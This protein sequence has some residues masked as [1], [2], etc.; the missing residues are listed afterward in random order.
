MPLFDPKKPLRDHIIILN[1]ALII[2]YGKGRKRGISRPA[3][4][5]DSQG[6][7]QPIGQCLRSAQLPTTTKPDD[8]PLPTTEAD[9]KGAWLFGGL[10]YQ[11]FGHALL[12][13]TAR[14]WARSVLPE[15][16]SVAFLMK[17]QMTWPNKFTRPMRPMMEMMS[18]GI[19]EM[20][21]IKVPT[22]VER[23]VVP[24]QA[25][26]TGTMIAGSPDFRAHVQAV[27]PQRVNPEGAEKIYISRSGLFSKRGRYFA[28]ARIEALLSAEGYRIYHPQTEDLAAQAA[29]Y[30]AAKVIISSD[31]S[32]LHL[33]AFFARPES[34]VA[35]VVRRPGNALGDYQ[36]QYRW[37]AQ[38]EPD[39][40]DA[41]N[42]RFYQ[43]ESAKLSQFSELYSELDFPRLGSMLAAKG[44]VQKPKLW[45]QPDPNE[46][47]AEQSELSERLGSEIF[48]AEALC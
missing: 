15:V 16:N 20:S 40:I 3:G 21:G 34:R 1:D 39:V 2:P 11:H 28:E 38:V 46:I 6:N 10:L 17:K 25:F 8:N 43:F 36:T 24:P 23:L 42:G 37:F 5:Y 44:Y 45:V 30:A 22:R 19:G 13:S 35:I 32:A 18:G 31:S 14:L 9:L 7:Y 41:L 27:L 47:K 48:L 12:E 33:A 29:Q 4:V 26:G